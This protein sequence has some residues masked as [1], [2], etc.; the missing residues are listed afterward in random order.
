MVVD[1]F[2]SLYFMS[3]GNNILDE[4]LTNRINTV[5]IKHGKLLQK[6]C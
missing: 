1:I 4:M 2:V 6:I 3:L 5:M